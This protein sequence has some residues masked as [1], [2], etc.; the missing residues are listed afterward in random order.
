V[1]WLRGSADAAEPLGAAVSA[2]SR[3]L[4][5]VSRQAAYSR[6][7]DAPLGT[8]VA[9]GFA[10]ALGVAVL[11]LAVTLIG[12]VIMSAAGR[13][14]DLAYLRTLGVSARQALA[15]TA[16]EHALPVVLALV[17]GV[18]LGVVVALLVEP[19][20]GLAAFTGARSV[21][22]FVDWPTL[23]LIAM[24]LAAVVVAAISM[25]TWMARRPRLASALRIE[26]R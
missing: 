20:L 15:L 26:D 25:G 14:R 17:P 19:G 2:A 10:V 7:R 22:L 12:A 18:L 23:G 5:V 13:T 11:Y 6:L 3:D 24:A 1:M 16:V 4:R 9:D 21:P 8:A